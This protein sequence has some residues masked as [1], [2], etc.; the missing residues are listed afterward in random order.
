MANTRKKLLLAGSAMVALSG[1]AAR[2]AAAA[3]A[4]GT[5]HA[6]ILGSAVG[7]AVAQ[8]MNFGSLSENGLGGTLILST[9]GGRT[10]GGGVNSFGAGALQGVVKI[11]AASGVPLE[12][13]LAA[14]KY[15]VTHTTAG[16]NKMT[17]DS[18]KLGA[19]SV[20]GILTKTLAGT[21]GTVPVGARLNVAG[22]QLSGNYLGSFTVNVTY[23]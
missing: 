22:G 2:E 8:N 9:A 16:A 23:Q 15:M 14:T 19:G 11:T 17:V 20:G 12:V 6:T 21:T 10:P 3:T 18:F 5:L 13:S 4:N 1:I 7:A